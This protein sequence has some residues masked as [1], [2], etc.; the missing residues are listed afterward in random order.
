MKIRNGFV[1]NS[2]SSSFVISLKNMSENLKSKIEK[3]VD[4]TNDLTRYTGIVTDISCWC[5]QD[6]EIGFDLSKY[7]GNKDI[8]IVRESDED[9]G[10]NFA[11][12][13]FSEEDLKPYVLD[14]FEW[15]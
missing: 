13:G 4:Y 10:G 3:M 12:Y 15:H 2:S 5:N 7:F 8:I 6:Y 9:M 1:S 14:E 11:D